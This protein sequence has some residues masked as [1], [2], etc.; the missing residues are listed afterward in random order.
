MSDFAY[1]LTVAFAMIVLAVGFV[2]A[3]VRRA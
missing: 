1:L 2:R 3:A